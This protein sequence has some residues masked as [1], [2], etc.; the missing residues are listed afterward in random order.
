M[1]R[2]GTGAKYGGN[3]VLS[4]SVSRYVKTKVTTV[5]AK[6]EN[7]ASVINKNVSFLSETTGVV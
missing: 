7:T 1:H 6:Y 5:V 2:T 3:S 4:G